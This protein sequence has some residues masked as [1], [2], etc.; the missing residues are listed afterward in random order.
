MLFA[1]L[2][3]GCVSPVPGANTPRRE[4]IKVLDYE[5]CLDAEKK[6]GGEGIHDH[7]DQLW[8]EIQH[9]DQ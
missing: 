2:L 3:C 9:A 1:L 7:C 8:Q 5:R 6:G 4:A